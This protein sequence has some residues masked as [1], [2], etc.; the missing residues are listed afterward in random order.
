[1]GMITGL[2]VLLFLCAF[3]LMSVKSP[4]EKKTRKHF[5]Q[6]LADF[7]EGT[8]E[9]VEGDSSENSFR[10][11]FRFKGEDFVYED[12]E[13]QGFNDKV[14]KAFLKAKT[15]NKLTLTFAEKKRSTK[16]KTDIFIASEIS[17]Q[18]VNE[19]IQVRVPT[20]LKDLKVLTNDPVATNKIFA[21]SK[22]ASIFKKFKN[23]DSRGY[24]FLCIGI[25]N[26]EVI[27]EFRSTKACHP[28]IFD[29]QA[30]VPSI[31]GYLEKLMVII[32]KLKNEL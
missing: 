7:L 28:N 12:L 18:Y 32:R 9:L 13:N 24:P 21:D 4:F 29:L 14:Y 11:K 22:T 30:D 8:L 3:I 16:I 27:L 6:E 20:Y 2:I 15:P 5:L 17:T 23:I 25:V 10:I 26:G 1:M 31:D 19:H